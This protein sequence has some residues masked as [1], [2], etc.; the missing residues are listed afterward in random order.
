MAA[1]KLQRGF[2]WLLVNPVADHESLLICGEPKPQFMI[3]VLK[4]G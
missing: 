2:E 1:Q 3:H 4:M